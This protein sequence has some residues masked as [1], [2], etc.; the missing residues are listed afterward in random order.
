MTIN[1]PQVQ[2]YAPI[3]A[4]GTHLHIC[5]PSFRFMGYEIFEN[6]WLVFY[7]IGL[8]TGTNVSSLVIVKT[9]T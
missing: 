2:Y 7:L 9:S 6:L 5:D 3:R 8:D 1:G 4:N